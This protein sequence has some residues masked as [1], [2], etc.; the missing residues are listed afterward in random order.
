MTQEIF[1]SVLSVLRYTGSTRLD[2]EEDHFLRWNI[3]SLTYLDLS[4]NN[5]TKMWQSFFRSLA[6][7]EKLYLSG[8]S[9]TT[10]HS[11]MFFY[12]IRL[13]RLSLSMNSITDIQQS[14]FQSY[15]KLNYLHMSG[16]KITSLNADLLRIAW[17]W[18]GLN[19]QTTVL[20]MVI[21]QHFEI[22]VS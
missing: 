3:T 6:F 2:L 15:S 22:T 17:K 21:R 4:Q 19:W 13:V 7:L 12:D 1:H 18:V 10:L 11:Q 8:N 16:N 5:I 9:T 20:L 14:S